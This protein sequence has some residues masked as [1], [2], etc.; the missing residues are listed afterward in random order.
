MNKGLADKIMSRIK[1]HGRGSGVY[2]AKDFLDLGGRAAVDQALSRLAKA[3]TLRRV[4]RGLYDW[5]L[6]GTFAAMKGK[7]LRPDV[8]SVVQAVARKNG[9]RVLPSGVASANALGLTNAVPTQPVMLTDGPS[10]TIEVLGMSIR[11]KH[12]GRKLLAW[13]DRPAFPV[14]NAIFWLGQHITDTDDMISFLRDSISSSII[15]DLK[16]GK[17][18]LPAWAEKVVDKIS[19]DSTKGTSNV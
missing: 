4:G 13:A 16:K 17:K 9:F 7:V 2:C 18:M 1:R 12:G 10:Q 19:Q 15:L 6:V 8:V 11:L 14:V 5:P 3:G